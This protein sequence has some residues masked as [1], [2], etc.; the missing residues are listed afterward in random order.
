MVQGRMPSPRVV[1]GLNV[2]EDGNFSFF[3][4][5][6]PLSV[7]AFRFQ[8]L[9]EAFGHG[10]VPAVSFSAHA[11]LHLGI[12]SEQFRELFA[13]V[14]NTSVRMKYQFRD[15]GPGH[16][17]HFLHVLSLIAEFN[18]FQLERPVKFSSFIFCVFSVF[19][20]ITFDQ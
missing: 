10:I 7:R 1:P 18:G 8:G 11:P 6:E 13:G 15:H 5:V 17:G 14:L 4:G 20:F 16:H 19:K 2:L 3:T 12:C 9:E